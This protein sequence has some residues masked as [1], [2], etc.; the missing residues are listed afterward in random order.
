MQI[1]IGDIG[2]I[3]GTQLYRI[4]LGSLPNTNYKY[5]HILI[6]VYLLIGATSAGLLWISM[7]RANAKL[8][9]KA[10]QRRA[11]GE[12]SAVAGE[13]AWKENWRYHP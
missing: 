1:T 5:S 3:A 11:R 9:Q 6:I 7:N 12:S 13:P 10:E 8:D 4:P 2:A